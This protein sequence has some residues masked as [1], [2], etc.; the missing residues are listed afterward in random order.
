MKNRHTNRNN[1]RVALLQ[2]KHLLKKYKSMNQATI[3]HPQF[4]NI[5]P[6]NNDN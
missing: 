1:H 6:I 2:K 4:R 3:L 5:F